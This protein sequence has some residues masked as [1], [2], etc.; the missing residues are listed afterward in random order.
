M[1]DF[2][3]C[4]LAANWWMNMSLNC[5][6]LSILSSSNWLYHLDMRLPR[7][8]GEALHHRYIYGL[9]IH[10]SF[11]MPNMFDRI[12][13][14]VVFYHRR[15]SKLGGKVLVRNSFCE[16]L[17]VLLVN[18]PCS[19][20]HHCHLF[21]DFSMSFIITPCMCSNSLFGYKCLHIVISLWGTSPSRTSLSSGSLRQLRDFL[22]LTLLD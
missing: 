16:F 10:Q 4:T 11:E 3:Y 7:V 18:A 8:I 1:S 22:R 15:G 2:L 17:P 12:S 6:K 20:L 14:F 5:W 19:R 21:R 9:S 13:T